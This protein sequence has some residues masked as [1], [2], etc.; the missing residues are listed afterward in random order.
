MS[1]LETRLKIK[2][3]EDVRLSPQHSLDC[4]YYNQG[5]DGG[6]PFLVEKFSNEFEIVPETCHPYTALNG[7]CSD[8][9]DV[10]L[11][12][13]IYK[14]KNYKFIGGAYGKSNEREMMLEIKNNGPIVA[15]F[16]PRYDFMYY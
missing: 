1:M 12:E 15:S 5:C 8:S 9:C 7:K 13:K 10:S 2:Y 4:N 3:G 11:L 16:E 14:V 6:Y